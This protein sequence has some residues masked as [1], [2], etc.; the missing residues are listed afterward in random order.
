M[1]NTIKTLLLLLAFVTVGVGFGSCA[2]IHEDEKIEVIRRPQT[3]LDPESPG[4]DD[5]GTDTID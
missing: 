1:K 4:W 5:G 2:K 3:D